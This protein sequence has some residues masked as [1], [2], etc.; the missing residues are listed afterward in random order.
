MSM[1]TGF[2]V[3]EEIAIRMMEFVESLD[4][5][6]KSMKAEKQEHLRQVNILN[7]RIQAWETK[8]SQLNLKT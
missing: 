6:V 2:N 8:I 1:D 3:D 5:E 7:S 4:N